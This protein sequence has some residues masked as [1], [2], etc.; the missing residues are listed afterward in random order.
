MLKSQKHWSFV[1]ISYFIY[2]NCIEIDYSKNIFKDG[3]DRPKWL[4]FRIQLN[5]VV[6]GLLTEFT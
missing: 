1:L 3:R 2:Q 5:V 4:T 6:K